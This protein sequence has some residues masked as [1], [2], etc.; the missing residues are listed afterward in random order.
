MW[1]SSLPPKLIV[2][3]RHVTEAKHSLKNAII[4]CLSGVISLV[5]CLKKCQSQFQ[6]TDAGDR[7]VFIKHNCSFTEDSVPD[8]LCCSR[9]AGEDRVVT[10]GCECRD[11]KSMFQEQWCLQIHCNCY[12]DHLQ[13]LL[14]LLTQDRLAGYQWWASAT[15]RSPSLAVENQWSSRRE[16]WMQFFSIHLF[17]SFSC[18]GICIMD[19]PWSISCSNLMMKSGL[20]SMGI[21]VTLELYTLRK[22]GLIFLFVSF[23]DKGR[24]R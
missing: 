23:W 9:L 3:E 19:F 21:K 8:S 6:R 16:G 13:W 4:V 20:E 1:F 22:R 18:S 17:I 2:S 24:A 7:E 12:S 10:S 11:R 5:L 14:L 15:M